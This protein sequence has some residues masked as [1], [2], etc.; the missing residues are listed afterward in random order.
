MDS[1]IR[2]IRQCTQGLPTNVDR[3]LKGIVG[4]YLDGKR[5]VEMIPEELAKKSAHDIE[6]T[7]SIRRV[8]RCIGDEEL[9]QQNAI[10][11]NDAYCAIDALDRATALQRGGLEASLARTGP[12]PGC[13]R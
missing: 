1:N 12:V 3:D 5:G 4:N 7:R 2:S 10:G 11:A 9:A 8:L 6:T 13:P